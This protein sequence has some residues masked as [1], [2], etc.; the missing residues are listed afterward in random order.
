[1]FVFVTF[2]DRFPV[3]YSSLPDYDDVTDERLKVD[4]HR[5]ADGFLI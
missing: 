4:A 1:M 2:G 5:L 3:M